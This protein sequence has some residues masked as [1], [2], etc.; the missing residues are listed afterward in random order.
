H[1]YDSL[2]IIIH[3][4]FRE[5][6]RQKNF[7]TSD[8][9]GWTQALLEYL[10]TQFDESNRDRDQFLTKITQ[11]FVKHT[12]YQEYKFIAQFI[13]DVV[14]SGIVSSDEMIKYLSRVLNRVG[15]SVELCDAYFSLIMNLMFDCKDSTKCFI[16]V[17]LLTLVSLLPKNLTANHLTIVRIAQ[18]VL[19]VLLFSTRQSL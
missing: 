13:E 16:L 11:L 10:K 14:T 8:V 6:K 9:V 7:L 3:L 2:K 18:K 12:A 17:E 15:D 4:A 19:H 1:R 5:H